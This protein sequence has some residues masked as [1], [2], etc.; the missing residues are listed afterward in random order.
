MEKAFAA[1]LLVVTMA[2][3]E[4]ENRGGEE[5]ANDPATLKKPFSGSQTTA[6]FKTCESRVCG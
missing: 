4:R 6:M 2:S 5:T 3:Q 1:M